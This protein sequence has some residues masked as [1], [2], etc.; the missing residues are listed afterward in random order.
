MRKL[1][2]IFIISQLTA[3][4][5]QH[6][7]IYKQHLTFND[8]FFGNEDAYQVCYPK[9]HRTFFYGIFL[10]SGIAAIFFC[11]I[12]YQKT[13]H[14]KALRSSNEI[15]SEKNKS[16]LDS[17]HY[18]KRIQTAILPSQSDLNDMAGAL[19]VLYCPRDIVSG[20]LYWVHKSKEG[21]YI[22]VI[23]CTGHGVPGAFLSLLAHNAIEQAIIE[24]GL[25]NTRQILDSMNDFVKAA[26]HQN[27][28]EGSKD[29]MEVGLCF[30][31]GN[32]V[33]Y[34]GANISLKYISDGKLNEIKAAKCSV[35]SVQ[36][37]VISLPQEHT[38]QLKKGD[39]IIMHSDGIIDQFGGTKNR[40]IT[41]K[42]LNDFIGKN[43]EKS[44]EQLLNETKGF[45]MDWKGSNE[46]TDDVLM[47][48]Y[49][50]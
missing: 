33:T 45:F 46:Q 11:I 4:A 2:F 24:K 25:K 47:M 19:H 50:I 29:G 37:N 3:L 44:A 34:S 31:N 49:E 16:I 9:E 39:K 41:S 38:V 43:I 26:L 7:G 23:D 28:E 32:T 12:I 30:I 40:K 48:V 13:K 10:A 6:D 14:N 8:T 21:V 27:T 5:Q 17:I 35:G 36:A 18:A 22:S 15:I 42:V 1:F 20:D